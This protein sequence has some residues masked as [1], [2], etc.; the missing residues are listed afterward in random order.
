MIKLEK[1]A[2]LSHIVHDNL[3]SLMK[4]EFF[5]MKVLCIPN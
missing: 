3:L 5:S 1:Q 2:R 4:L